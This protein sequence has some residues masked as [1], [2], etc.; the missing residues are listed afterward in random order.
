[1]ITTH[2]RPPSRLKTAPI[3]AS[4][5]VVIDAD[6]D[7]VFSY[8]SHLEHNPQ[9][10]WAITSTTALFEG[11]PRPGAT[12]LQGR[13]FP[14]RGE[15]T[16]RIASLRHNEVLEV[17]ATLDGGDAIY[18]YDLESTSSGATRVTMT[19]NLCLAVRGRSDLYAIRLSAAMAANL[20]DLEMAISNRRGDA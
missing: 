6:V 18:R 7:T 8:L 3:Q 5:T 2:P 12:Y 11:P 14:Q 13:S 19:L 9:W 1:M 16:L 4:R 17:A 20:L 15:E 10:N